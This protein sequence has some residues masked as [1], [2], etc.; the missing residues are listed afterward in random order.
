MRG[1]WTKA[2]FPD[3]F[4]GSL[5]LHVVET[6]LVPSF[7]TESDTRIAS[8]SGWNATTWAENGPIPRTASSA[9]TISTTTATP[10]PRKIVPWA[11]ELATSR[12]PSGLHFSQSPTSSGTGAPQRAQAW[13]RPVGA[14]GRGAARGGTR[15]LH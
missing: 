13:V 5:I 1:D 10:I 9:P 12:S 8:P 7:L 3:P 11:C 15:A 4:V 2:A 14:A 6:R